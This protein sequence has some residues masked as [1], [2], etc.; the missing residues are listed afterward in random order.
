MLQKALMF[1]VM[2]TGKRHSEAELS[3]KELGE[4]TSSISSLAG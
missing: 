4:L 1:A 3:E 2:G